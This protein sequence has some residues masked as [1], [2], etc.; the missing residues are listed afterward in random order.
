MADEDKTIDYKLAEHELREA[1][2]ALAE[3]TGEAAPSFIDAQPPYCSFCG[4]GINQVMRMVQGPS[5]HICDECVA[6]AQNI[7]GES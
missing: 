5:V 4:K 6:A 3:L 7:L 2:R 1:V